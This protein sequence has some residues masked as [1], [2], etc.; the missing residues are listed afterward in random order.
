[1]TPNIQAAAER[2]QNG[3]P[4]TVD[5]R[6][7]LHDDACT[8]ASAYLAALP[9]LAVLE[10]WRNGTPLTEEWVRSIGG[11]TR[12]NDSDVIDLG[13][14]WFS[15]FENGERFYGILDVTGLLGFEI[16]TRGQLRQL[17]AVLGI[18]LAEPT[19]EST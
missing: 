12:E 11:K 7:I 8:L 13:P 16:T 9:Q 19:G 5:G 14:V 15:Y 3:Y 2:F 1:M 4:P 18:P 10:R 6:I 17:C